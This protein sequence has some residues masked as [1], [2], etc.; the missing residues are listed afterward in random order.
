MRIDFE[1]VQAGNLFTM[2]KVMKADQCSIYQ[3]NTSVVNGKAIT[4]MLVK[5]D[6]VEDRG[7]YLYVGY[8]PAGKGRHLCVFGATR[9]YKDGPKEFGVVGFEVLEKGRS[10]KQAPMKFADIN[11]RFT[12]IVTEYLANGYT[13]NTATMAG[14]QGEVGKVDLTDGTRVVRVLLDGF[15]DTS[16][17]YYIEGLKITVGEAEGIVPNLKDRGDA[18]WNER[19]K[20]L[21][22]ECFYVVGRSHRHGAVYGTREQAEAAECLRVKRYGTSTSSRQTESIIKKYPQAVE[23][24]KRIIRRE[25]GVKRI[26]Q[27]DVCFCKCDGAYVVSYHGKVYRLGKRKGA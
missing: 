2:T 4:K 10:W 1:K 26:Q 13:I 17:R 14:S 5:V 18:I 7:E 8:T 25:F 9:L 3:R 16:D 19:L 12:E 22:S 24:A 6:W 15:V 21:S 23:L 20:V 27:D 11:K